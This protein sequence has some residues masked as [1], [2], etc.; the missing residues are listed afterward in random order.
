MDRL[1][2]TCRQADGVHWLLVRPDGTIYARSTFG[3]QSENEALIDLGVL[4][5]S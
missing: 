4:K 5:R 1:Y 2:S 3:F